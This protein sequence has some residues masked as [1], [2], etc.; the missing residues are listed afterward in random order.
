METKQLV[1]FII[2][3]YDICQS[4]YSLI[5]DFLIKQKINKFSNI[6]T[7]IKKVLT[8]DKKF[9]N[10]SDR[11]KA[12]KAIGKDSVS[13]LSYILRY[14]EEEGLKKRTERKKELS[15][16][17]SKKYLSNKFGE[18]YFRKMRSSNLTTLI[19]KHGKEEGTNRWNEYLIKFKHSHSI[20]GY[21]E[22][23]GKEKGKEL[24]NKKKEKAQRKN[25]YDG[26]VDRFGESAQ[27]AWD[28]K[29]AKIAYKNSK[30]YYIEIYGENYKEILRRVKD[31][32]SLSSLQSKY[33]TDVGKRLYK[34]KCKKI[35][36][37]AKEQLWVL[38]FKPENF[39]SKVSQ[40]FFTELHAL[41]GIEKECMYGSNNGE[42]FIYDSEEKRIY[43]YD[44]AHKNKI[45][46]FHGDYWHKNPKF[47]ETDP[48]IVEKDS[49]KKKLVESQ[50]RELLTIWEY[51]YYTDPYNTLQ[52]A[53]NFLTHE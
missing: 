6:P 9:E 36:D 20:E 52:T 46:E 16:K 38:H 35:S 26:F 21:I 42:Y 49:K 23:Y 18:D 11:L 37:I 1:D 2:K 40:L 25:S 50:G 30:S 43:F 31:N 14:G 34:D 13:E 53:L 8:Y 29:N 17:S 41:L 7:P 24:Y 32:N 51:D 48:A 15:I 3:K 33:G 12:I 39:Y 4:K 47:Y 44:F 5:E 28:E 19:E 10:L 27:Q 45:I 22:K